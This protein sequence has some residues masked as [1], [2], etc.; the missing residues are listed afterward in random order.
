MVVTK[1]KCP[2]ETSKCFKMQSQE[3][4]NSD[5]KAITNTRFKALKNLYKAELL[6]AK[7]ESWK[8]FCTDYTK[9]MPWKMYKTCKAGFARQ[10]VLTSLTL[11]GGSV[12]TTVEETAEA[13]LHK[14]FSQRHYRS[15]QCSTK[16]H[17]GSHI[18][19]RAPRLPDRAKLFETRSG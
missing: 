13:L 7:L 3:M 14:F 1:T 10:P 9:N 2:K 8:K 6:R 4:K 11:S 17:Q 18:R 12:T 16:E 19:T 15:R 5:L